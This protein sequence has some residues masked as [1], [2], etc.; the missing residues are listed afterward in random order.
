M[1]HSGALIVDST[2]VLQ[3]EKWPVHT[4]KEDHYSFKFQKNVVLFTN[5]S[6]VW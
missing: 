6:Q 1:Q 2:S 3:V 4:T 5:E